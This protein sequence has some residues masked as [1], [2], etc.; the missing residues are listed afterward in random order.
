MRKIYVDTCLIIAY[1]HAN[2]P[3]NQHKR[4]IDFFDRMK[5]MDKIELC[6]SPFTL[7]EFTQAYVTINKIT[8]EQAYKIANS[9]LISNKIDRKYTFSLLETQGKEKNY[10]FE[11]FFLDIQTVL[12]NT[13]PRPGIADAIHA[14]IMKN[15]IITEVVT[16]NTHDFKKIEKIKPLIPEDII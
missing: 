10:K 7:T 16:F 8:D 14:T 3:N 6:C 12:L 9:L 5:N 15:N 4:A 2:D 13:T 11:D 1:H